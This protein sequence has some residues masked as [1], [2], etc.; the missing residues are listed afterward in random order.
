M[1]PRRHHHQE[2]VVDNSGDDEPAWFDDPNVLL[3]SRDLFPTPQQ[4]PNQRLNA[5]AR[6]IIVV[7]LLVFAF[8]KS[9]GTLLL[10]LVCAAGLALLLVLADPMRHVEQQ[11]ADGENCSSSNS[12]G[13]QQHVGRSGGGGAKKKPRRAP[14]KE[15]FVA[16]ANANDALGADR[17]NVHGSVLLAADEAAVAFLESTKTAIEGSDG[18][19]Q[20]PSLANPFGNLLLSDALLH[21]DR[22]PAPKLNTPAA[23]EAVYAAMEAQVRALHPGAGERMFASDMDR[24]QFRQSLRPFFTN[25][26]TTIVP[27]ATG[28]WRAMMPNTGTMRDGGTEHGSERRP[29]FKVGTPGKLA[30]TDRASNFRQAADIL[31]PL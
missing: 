24:L 6:A 30:A 4:S 10:G 14:P 19:V 1:P 13:E 11:P 26:S 20:P 28:A 9:V 2:V 22:R 21:P 27:D 3:R 17:E 16:A 29:R 18:A 8:T 15:G 5:V 23:R 12:N 25:P 7:T 31:V